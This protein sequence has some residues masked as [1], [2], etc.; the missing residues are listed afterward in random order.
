MHGYPVLPNCLL[1]LINYVCACIC[2]RMCV[3]IYIYI[4][5]QSGTSKT[6]LLR[7]RC[8]SKTPSLL[9]NFC[10][11]FPAQHSLAQHKQDTEHGTLPF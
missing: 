7:E 11:G 3:Y 8:C 2:V 10:L 9:N 5:I 4:Y 6:I 1:S